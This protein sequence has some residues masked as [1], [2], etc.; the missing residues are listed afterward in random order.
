MGKSLSVTWLLVS[1]LI[2]KPARDP[3]RWQTVSINLR[4]I[5]EPYRATLTWMGIGKNDG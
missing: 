1:S 2:I 4:A 3:V 5:D